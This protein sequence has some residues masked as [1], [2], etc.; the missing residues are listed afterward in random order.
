VSATKS[1]VYTLPL[2]LS[3]VIASILNGGVS[4]N[5]R[6][7]IASPCMLTQQQ[8]TQ[9]IGYYVPAM[10]ASPSILAVGLG[11]MST[12]RVDEV[13]SHWIAYQFLGGFGLGIGMQ[14]AG[15]AAQAVLPKPDIPMG[16]AIMFFMQQLGGAIFT[17]VGQ[18]LL[19]TTLIQ[20]LSSLTGFDP[21]TVVGVG[22]T[23]IV[24]QFPEDQQSTVLAIYNYA[25]TRIFLCAMGVACA[26]TLAA[27]CME[28]KN[29]KKS[30]PPAQS[31][32]E[33]SKGKNAGLSET[34]PMTGTSTPEA[35]HQRPHRISTDF[36][37]AMPSARTSVEKPK[38]LLAVE[39]DERFVSEK[40][41]VYATPRTRLSIEKPQEKQSGD[42][43]PVIRT[44]RQLSGST[45]RSRDAPREA[46][47][48]ASKEVKN[49]K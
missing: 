12:F 14:S 26:G 27:L 39:S 19:S 6:R 15:L 7:G 35:T 31:E 23:D 25:L 9:K 32:N 28:W 42:S 34:E 20:K 22:A 2:V 48:Q 4:R 38:A 18:N 41:S 30:G 11:L 45:S 37:T 5:S 21:S 10:I 1:G 47:E 13:R 46:E 16:I 8:I 17:S 43:L 29:V 3:M 36:D 24:S 33:D 44:P 49:E 40:A